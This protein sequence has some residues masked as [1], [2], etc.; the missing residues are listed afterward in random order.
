MIALTSDIH[1]NLPA[2]EAVLSDL[3]DDVNG[4]VNAGDTVGYNPFPQECADEIR[5]R[6]AVSVQGNHDRAVAGS[7]S[8]G[9]HS[10]A[11]RAVEWTR[12]RLDD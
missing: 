3:P 7:T 5:E 1:G 4:Y 6:D 8:F 2:L 11:G 9:F 10:T 12:E